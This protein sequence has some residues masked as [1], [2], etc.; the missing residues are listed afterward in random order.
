MEEVPFENE[1][2]ADGM[3]P[4]DIEV[5]GQGTVSLDSLIN[6]CS[7]QNANHLQENDLQEEYQILDKAS[8]EVIFEN[9]IQEFSSELLSEIA[10]KILS[11]SALNKF[12]Q[13]LANNS[14]LNPPEKIE[15]IKK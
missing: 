11:L 15:I 6:S 13:L 10:D 14:E 2:I 12:R 7:S 8:E 4:L 1:I 3:L 5:P 9:N